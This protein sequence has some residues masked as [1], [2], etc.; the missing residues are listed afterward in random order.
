MILNFSSSPLFLSLILMSAPS[1]FDLELAIYLTSLFD[2]LQL[3][4]SFHFVN[5]IH[6]PHE[7]YFWTILHLSQDV[8][9]LFLSLHIMYDPFFII[10]FSKSISLVPITDATKCFWCLLSFHVLNFS[11]IGFFHNLAPWLLPNS[12]SYG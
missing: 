10:V 5:L 1:D 7:L 9:F 3:S 2:G 12:V 11:Y 4:L 8:S 6:F